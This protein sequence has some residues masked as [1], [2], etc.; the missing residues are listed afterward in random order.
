MRTP[1]L[2]I[3]VASLGLASAQAQDGPSASD[4]IRALRPDAGS[5]GLS[6]GIILGRPPTSSEPSQPRTQTDDRTTPEASPRA[7]PSV[8]LIVQFKTNSAELTP[9]ARRT[10]DELGNALSNAALAEYHFRIEGHT[11]TVGSRAANK[12]LSERRAAAVVDYLAGQFGVDRAR[13]EAVGMGDEAPL[14]P[15][16]PQTPEQRNRRVRVVNMGA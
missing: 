13:L 15:T 16:P 4:I 11:D 3:M 5:G 12:A 7:A 10:L 14:V 8:N 9:S 6:R 1:I 2:A